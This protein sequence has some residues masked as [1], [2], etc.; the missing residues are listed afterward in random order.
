MAGTSKR[1]ASGVGWIGLGGQVS[2]KKAEGAAM[3]P[4][5]YFYRILEL[6][7]KPGDTHRGY[8]LQRATVV[9]N[10]VVTVEEIG[11]PNLFE[12]IATQASDFMDPRNVV[13]P[14]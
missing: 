11:K 2:K 13:K 7:L 12:Y 5:D 1:E 10:A 4:Q 14:E 8:A 3:P 6:P 9:G